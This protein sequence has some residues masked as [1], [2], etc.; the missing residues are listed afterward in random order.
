MWEL[1]KLYTQ[2]AL[3]R[4]GPQD[5]PASRL[6]L[7]LTVIAYLAMNLL[8]NSLLPP[9]GVPEGGAK[10]SDADASSW[11]AQLL[12]DSAFTLVWYAVLLRA[13]RRPE[14]TLQTTTAVFGFQIVLAPLLF[15]S[16]WLWPRFMHDSTW[17]VPV[18]LF[19]IVLLVWLIA[20][21]SHIVKVALE[22]SGGASVALV[23]LQILAGELLRR[24]LFFSAAG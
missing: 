12:L 11:P 13:A 7:V 23:I 16:S 20:A 15:F 2:I 17:G 24:A 21:N 22:W 6:L 8:M 5:L 3:L 10:V 18:A 9:A 19:G 14:R 4:R 1:V